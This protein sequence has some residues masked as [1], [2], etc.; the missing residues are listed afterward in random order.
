MPP[1]DSQRRS[2][3]LDRIIHNLPDGF[4]AMRAEASAEGYRN[5]ERLALDWTSGAMHFEGEGEALLAARIQG[6]L[7]GIGGLT[8]EPVVPG[9]FRMRRFYVRRPFRRQGIGRRL[10]IALIEPALARSRVITVNAGN[11]D[12]PAFWLRLGFTPDLRDGHTH[13]LRCLC[14]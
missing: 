13:V 2:G 5:L 9:A 12:A 6:T 11:I 4:D 7:A 14:V 3:E 10:P 1:V 8:I